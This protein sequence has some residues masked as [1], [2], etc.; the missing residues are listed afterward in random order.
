ML[1]LCIIEMKRSFTFLTLFFL[2]VEYKQ[3][4]FKF[5]NNDICK[6]S[7]IVYLKSFFVF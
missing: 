1:E 3:C 5:V 6:Q 4:K 7:T 2:E